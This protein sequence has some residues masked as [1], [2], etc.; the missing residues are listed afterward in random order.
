MGVIRNIKNSIDDKS[1]MSVCSITLLMSA[2]I[3]AIIGL[4]VCF[5][6]IWDVTTNGYIKTD[7]LD[8]GIFLM[9]GGAYIAGSGIPKTVVDSRMKTRSW[10][11]GEK[12]QIE[13]EEDIED[14]KAERRKRRRKLEDDDTPSEDNIT[15]T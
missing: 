15:E 6:L 8:L 5:V 13:A 12:M 7:L 10:I 14:L 9:S 1:S 3:G 11:E 4:V 2:M